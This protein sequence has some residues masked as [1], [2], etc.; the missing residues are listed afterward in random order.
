MRHMR[1][2]EA[3]VR[4]KKLKFHVSIVQLAAVS[5]VSDQLRALEVRVEQLEAEQGR[6][7]RSQAEQLRCSENKLSKRVTSMESSL[8]QELQLL[9]QEYHKGGGSLSVVCCQR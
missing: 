4:I 5:R 9:K 3:H 8:H 6:A 1:H 2:C 7:T